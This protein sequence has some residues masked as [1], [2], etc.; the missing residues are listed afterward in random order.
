MKAVLL[1]F[2]A[3]L[4][5]RRLF[6]VGGDDKR[7]S[8][9]VLLRRHEDHALGGYVVIDIRRIIAAVHIV[10]ECNGGGDR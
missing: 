3:G 2:Y 10:P 6:R 8:G 9:A 5:N 1:S 4:F 7:R